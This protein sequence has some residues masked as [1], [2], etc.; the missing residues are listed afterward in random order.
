MHPLKDIEK[1]YPTIAQVSSVFIYS[2][3]IMYPNNYYFIPVSKNSFSLV[4]KTC[5]NRRSA[6][7]RLYEDTKD[8]FTRITR[9]S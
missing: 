4:N 5:K 6:T 2:I 7:Y 9:I 8:G 3:L 1:Y